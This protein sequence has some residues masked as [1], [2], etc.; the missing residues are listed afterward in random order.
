[1]MHSSVLPDCPRTSRVEFEISFIQNAGAAIG[2]PSPLTQTLEAVA[3]NDSIRSIVP[4]GVW[5]GC[6]TRLIPCGHM[7]HRRLQIVETTKTRST[8]LARRRVRRRQHERN[9]RVLPEQ[10]IQVA[11]SRFRVPDLCV[12]SRKQRLEPVFTEPPLICVEI[13][14]KQ[15]S[16]HSLQERVDDYRA[17]GIPNIWVL[18]PDPA[19]PRAYVCMFGDF[20]EPEGGLLEVP[21]SPIRVP[22]R[23]LFAELG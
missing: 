11:P 8:G 20:R 15:D 6:S 7:T 1:M 4:T 17:F 5:R 9:I 22:L 13:L 3:R 16:L 12:V 21:D 2:S 10:R 14:S 19:R 18:N 23:D